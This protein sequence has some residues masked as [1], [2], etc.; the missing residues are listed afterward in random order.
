MRLWIAAMLAFLA[1]ACSPLAMF[2]GLA[3]KDRL[4]A[5]AVRDIAYGPNPRQQLDVYAAPGT[6]AKPVI[7]FFY[8]GGWDSGRRQDYA[9]AARALAAQGFVTVV[10]DYRLVPEVRF[11]TFLED[12]AAAVR[13]ARDHAAE[14]GGDPD[15]IVIMG[16]S[17][18]AYNAAMLGLDRRYLDTAGVPQAAIRGVIGLAG[19]YDFYPWDADAS[20]NAF[21]Q[22]AEP[23]Q[24]QPVTFARADAP[25]LLLL[26]GDKDPTVRVRN[27]EHLAA[28]VREAGGRVE[29]KI[30]PGVDHRAIV[31][32]LSRPFRGRATTLADA[33]AF[34][35][36]VT[37]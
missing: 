35:R 37:K 2:N 34:A 14:H 1:S 16:H 23:L 21:G 30:Y 4:A 11:P 20:R 18:G 29:M 31:L 10:P 3:P 8:G 17:A 6:G 7:V 36:D 13:W 25:P 19:P 26:H 28:R 33:T 15:R 24:T 9:W 12:S 5:P 27:T 22:Y 32:A